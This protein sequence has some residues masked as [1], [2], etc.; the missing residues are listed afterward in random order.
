MNAQQ[1]LERF[2]ASPNLITWDKI[3]S[4]SINKLSLFIS[5]LTRSRPVS[6]VIPFLEC[7]RSFTWFALAFDESSLMHLREQI[8]SFI[9]PTYSDFNGYQH[10]GVPHVADPIVEEFTRGHF[11]TFRGDENTIGEKVKLMFQLQEVRPER[12]SQIPK[13]PFQILHSFE[14]AI[15]ARDEGHAKDQIDL[16]ERYRL[17][18]PRNALFMRIEMMSS[19]ERWQ[20]IVHHPQMEDLLKASRPSRIT[21]SLIR[22]VYRFYLDGHK[23]DPEMLTNKFLEVVWPQYQSLYR[24][25]GALTHPDTLISF[26]L[27]AVHPDMPLS[28]MQDELLL[29]G[30]GSE[31][32]SILHSLFDSAKIR[33]SSSATP[34]STFQEARILTERGQ[35]EEAFAIVSKLEYSIEKIQLMLLCAFEIQDLR[36]DKCVVD[37]ISRLSEDEL[38]S[39]LSSR[40]LKV[41]YTYLFPNTE[42]ENQTIRT[43]PIQI[44]T[45]WNEWFD[46]LQEL[47]PQMA[48]DLA[49]RGVTEWDREGFLSNPTEVEILLSHLR[50]DSS[51]TQNVVGSVL[52]FLQRYLINDPKWPRQELKSIYT[53]LHQRFLSRMQGVRSEMVIAAEWSERLLELGLTRLEYQ[54]LFHELIEGWN[55]LASSDFLQILYPVLEKAGDRPCPDLHSCLRFIH[56][57]RSKLTGRSVLSDH[58]WLEIEERFIPKEWVTWYQILFEA[59]E[60]Y[61]FLADWVGRVGVNYENWSPSAKRQINEWFIHWIVVET[62]AAKRSVIARS[63]S[64]FVDYVT[65]DPNFPENDE[66]EFY[67]TLADMLRLFAGKNQLTIQ[68]LLRLIDGLLLKKPEATDTQW[69]NMRDWMTF[70]PIPNLLAS[71]YDCLELFCDYGVPGMELEPMWNEWTGRLHDKLDE[72]IEW[73]LPYLID[74]G[75]TIAGN[76]LT[77]QKLKDLQQC[78]NDADDPLMG[79]PQMTITIFSCREKAARRAAD[80]ITRRNAKLKTRVCTLD[81]PNEQ[82]T[83]YARQ[84]DL[85]I[86]VTSCISHALTYGIRDQLRE[87]PIYPRSSG[88]AGIIERFEVYAR[89]KLSS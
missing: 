9:G 45:N 74:L 14:L 44:P 18:D 87:E 81:R 10:S 61:Q 51:Q 8:R 30:L 89:E 29:A 36:V 67:E 64:P 49:K 38:R 4:G 7:D 39:V 20:D 70:Q 12:L 82:T 3:Q 25:R 11:F 21:E 22:A 1:F 56:Y 60:D 69:R 55:R 76:Y 28:D 31:A 88:E 85:S 19:F 33:G 75:E 68:N 53:E 86:V 73:L 24:V 84:S 17:I 41:C 80:Q 77:L 54:K 62:E 46:R 50:N 16:L 26:M 15:Q 2:F 78:E 59:E 23:N 65:R 83:A 79:L 72:Q 6:T 27:R 48:H 32:E 47:E 13:D 40:Q 57:I 66:T 58:K 34:G 52:P 63:L 35:Y 71:V 37:V 42:V 43:T 5:R